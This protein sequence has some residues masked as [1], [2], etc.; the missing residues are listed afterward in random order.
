[1]RPRYPPRALLVTAL[2]VGSALLAGAGAAQTATLH[3]DGDEITLEAGEGQAISGQTNLEPGSTVTVTVRSE[4]SQSPFLSRPEAE[5]GEDGQFT[6]YVDLSHVE[7][8]SAATVSV[9]H[10]RDDLAEAS[11]RVA[12]CDGGC[13]PVATIDQPGAP[14]LQ[15]GPG[16]EI[17][18]E[19]S[20]GSGSSVTVRLESADAREPFLVSKETLVTDERAFSTH[21]DLSNV[22][23]G[24]PVRVA[25][26]HD[27]E[28]LNET[29][30][31]VDACQGG[32]EPVTTD[33]PTPRPAIDPSEL[34]F[35][36]I[37]EVE[38]TET[39]TI[40]VGLGEADAATLVVGSPEVNYVTAATVS[41]GNGDN[42]VRVRFDAAAAGTDNQT[43][44]V[45]DEADELA[46]TD[47]EPDVD[48]SIDATDYDMELYE[49]SSTD[50]DSEAVGALVVLEAGPAEADRL[51]LERD[52]IRAEQGSAVDIPIDLGDEDAA[53]LVVG[54]DAV[55]YGVNATV[56]DGDGDGRVVLTFRTA[57]AGTDRPTF[58]TA[59][60]DDD[61]T[62][63]DPEPSLDGPLPSTEYHLNLYPGHQAVGDPVAIGTLSVG[64]ESDVQT[65][66]L[67]DSQS[68]DGGLDLG[69]VGALAAG[70]VFAVVGVALL[71]GLFRS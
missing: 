30:T 10:D 29:S 69:G 4:N 39:A 60:A 65:A 32:C 47:P 11:A 16:Q 71:L 24:T 36:S 13:K 61:V 62:I 2:L 41:D 70:A 7:P 45:A 35:R 23:P 51:A 27:G 21:F 25:V 18:G 28:Q 59:A 40:P 31:E 26:L 52:V 46:V 20:L 34:G 48:G 3:Y 56:S 67:D 15:S 6:V 50:G 1:M 68:G 55:G 57:N 66:A 53:T 64:S 44:S 12:E 54:R 38:T 49:G 19:T 58:E 8:G 43:F 17:A 42:I 9:S 22:D 37:V 63:A 5:V 14:P 33:T